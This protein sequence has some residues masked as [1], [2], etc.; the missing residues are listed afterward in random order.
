MLQIES[1]YMTYPEEFQLCRTCP[2]RECQAAGYTEVT[3]N[4]RLHWRMLRY[5]ICHHLPILCKGHKSHSSTQAESKAD[6]SKVHQPKHHY[7]LTSYLSH[8]LT[9]YPRFVQSPLLKV[10][11][12]WQVK[13]EH[14]T[15]KEN[16]MAGLVI[17][18]ASTTSLV[19]RQRHRPETKRF[20]S[21]NVNIPTE[22]VQQ[23]KW[24]DLLQW[25]WPRCQP[26]P[27]SMAQRTSK[28]L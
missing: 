9:C 24:Q 8:R 2:K 26:Q 12:R 14:L 3:H 7:R 18:K 20:L 23:H 1:R 10:K 17:M 6:R 5:R 25:K 19:K 28:N 27:L 22:H 11:A 4:F 16:A 15:K 13:A 21:W